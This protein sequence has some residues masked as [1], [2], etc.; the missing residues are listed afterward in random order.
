MKKCVLV[1]P[2]V[3]LPRGLKGFD[4]LIDESLHGS[5]ALGSV[6]QVPLRN[7]KVWGVINAIHASCRANIKPILQIAVASASVSREDRT[8]INWFSEYYFVS[9]S[10]AALQW[11]P[12]FI[13]SATSK[14]KFFQKKTTAIHLR[15]LEQFPEIARYYSQSDR[16]V[17]LEKMITECLRDNGQILILV[18]TIGESERLKVILEIKYRDAIAILHSALPAKIFQRNSIDAREGSAAIVI[19]TRLAVFTPMKN[20]RAIA[21]D[22]SDRIEYKQYDANPRYDTRT[23]ALMRA[24]LLGARIAFSTVAPRLEELH[25]QNAFLFSEQGIAP[26][27]A[28]VGLEEEFRNNNYSF[29]SD[30]L[31]EKISETIARNKKVCL[32]LNKTGYSRMVACGTCHSVFTCEQCNAVPRYSSQ[33]SVLM[34]SQ[35]ELEQSLPARCPFCKGHEYTFPGIGIEK[36][37]LSI[38]KLWGSRAE[39]FISVGTS[40]AF[41]QSDVANVGLLGCIASDP[42]VSLWEF[43]SCERQWQSYAQCIHLALSRGAEIII[44]AIS[45]TS[46][47][48]QSLSRLDYALFAKEELASR[49]KG[50]WPPYARL[51]KIMLKRSANSG[52]V[53]LDSIIS[54]I[55][56]LAAESSLPVDVVPLLSTRKK[57]QSSQ[58]LIK[59]KAAYQPLSPIPDALKKYLS[60]LPEEMSI[61][62]DPVE[63]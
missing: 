4:Y 39:S 58:I 61:D 27:C 17:H 44:Q 56:R 33:K 48:I 10:T 3:R 62:I 15:D 41:Q 29:I 55:K 50:N 2:F 60:A 53:S 25:P 52:T 24:H 12:F 36:I 20:L 18:P 45:P 28:I 38:K 22:Q 9:P 40:F 35:C 63:L 34:C 31:K 43:R 30:A 32:V 21:L 23:V 6:V 7:K 11:A 5:I 13:A 54:D 57:K 26:S 47:F 16:I 51:I 37:N 59:L 49:R 1:I 8:L 19:G 42:V 14:E 46:I